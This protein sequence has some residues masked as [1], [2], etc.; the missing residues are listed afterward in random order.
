MGFLTLRSFL[1]SLALH[2][3]V[4]TAL[5]VNFDTPRTP[6]F[7]PEPAENI[8]EA[9]TVDDQAVEQ[10]L[11]RLRELEQEKQ[12]AMENKLK[13]LEEQARTV[14]EK[15]KEAEREKQAAE[16]KRKEEEKRKS[17]AERK[18]KEE[19]KRKSEAERKRKEEERRTTRE[20]RRIEQEKR[21]AQAELKRIEE[22]N[23]K[24]QAER[25]R[26][27]EEQRKAEE[28]R[29]RKEEA[30]RKKAAEDA[31][32]RRL[33]QEQQAQDNKTLQNIVAAM[34]REVSGNFNKTG[35]PKGLECVLSVQ[36]VPGGEVI[37]VT[38]NKSS[39]NEVFDRRAVTAVEKASPLPLPEDLAVFERL[40][41][42]KFNFIF[43]PED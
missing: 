15:R 27:E 7:K 17:E 8:V 32:R 2:V 22:E 31:E 38:V 29:K 14:E 35:L 11:Q 21:E 4:I 9:V 23:R 37:S 33:A 10:E 12:R 28:E 16:R 5:V 43:K 34:Y 40:R 13:A 6:V 42:R 20:R 25:A 30:E 41:L 19:E 36:T 1:Y 39:G 18:R 26:L 24:A 3:V